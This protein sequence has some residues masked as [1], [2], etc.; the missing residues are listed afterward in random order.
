MRGVLQLNGMHT[1]YFGITVA[2]PNTDFCKKK[3]TYLY[4]PFYL[5]LLVMYVQ[6]AT[7]HAT[8]RHQTST[9]P[10]TTLHTRL[11]RKAYFNVVVRM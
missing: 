7:D 6:C 9:S 2:L 4:F 10:A 1:L 3:N 5:S 8:P 11:G